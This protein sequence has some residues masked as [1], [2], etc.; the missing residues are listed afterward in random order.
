MT[1]SFLD[2]ARQCRRFAC[3]LT[4]A[5]EAAFLLKIACQFEDLHAMR[6]AAAA[7]RHTLQG[8]GRVSARARDTAG[9]G[10]Q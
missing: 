5:T 10:E 2:E 7:G 1:T 8:C 6:T 4:G 9:A 3:E